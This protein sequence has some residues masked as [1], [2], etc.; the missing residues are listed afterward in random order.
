MNTLFLDITYTG[1]HLWLGNLA[2]LGI[3]LSFVGSLLAV[4][5]Y[6]H[7]TRNRL[8]PSEPGWL[9]VGRVGFGLH[10]LGVFAVIALIFTAMLNQWYEYKYVFDH[11]SPEL[12]QQYIFS[13][14]WEG[15]EGSFLLWMFWNAILGV[16]VLLRGGKFEAPVLVMI[17]LL[18]LILCS[19]I[20]GIKLPWWNEAGY[21]VLGSNPTLL[22]REAM[23]APIFSRPD[24]VNM[25][26]GTGLNPLLQNYWMTIHPPTLFLG[27]ASV[28]L[29]F[30]HAFAGL[31]LNDRTDWIQ[32]TLRWSLFSAA[33]LG[34]GILMGGAWAYVAL[35]FGGYWA[36]DPVENMSLVPWILL[37]AG[38]HT[39]LITRATK[40]GLRS[41]YAFLAAAFFMILFSTFLTRSGVL[42]ESSVHAFTEMGLEVQ[43]VIMLAVFF[44]IGMFGAVLSMKRFAPSEQ[45]SESFFSRELWMVMGSLILLV[46]A[47]LISHYTSIPVYNQLLSY[48][49]DQEINAPTDPVDHHNRMQ[50]FVGVLIGLASGIAVFLRF[51]ERRFIH[52][53]SLIFIGIATVLSAIGTAAWLYNAPFIQAWQYK[54]LAFS[55]VFAV[56][57]N[58]L[59]L[60]DISFDKR[61]RKGGTLFQAAATAMS[62]VGFGLMLIGVLLSGLDKQVISKGFMEVNTIEGFDAEEAAKNVLLPRGVPTQLGEYTATYTEDERQGPYRKFFVDFVKTD[63]QT[64]KVIESFTL[65]PNVIYDKTLSKIEASNPSTQHYW[66][67][68]V[69]TYASAMPQSETDAQAAQKLEDSLV[70]VTHVLKPSDTLAIQNATVKLEQIDRGGS[71][72]K[73]KQKEGDLV[74][75]AYVSVN[76]KTGYKAMLKPLYVIRGNRQLNYPDVDKRAGVKVKFTGLD[77]GSL[78][79]QNPELQGVKLEIAD[80]VVNDDYIVLQ[81][82]VFPGINLVWIGSIMMMFGFLVAL[83]RR[84]MMR[85]TAARTSAVQQ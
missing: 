65:T 12:N 25:I 54:L 17:A 15:Q 78:Q 66:N 6:F 58:S 76:T 21:I 31:W 2:H 67:Q 73:Y 42:G 13:A 71:H 53:R 4:S 28:T 35:T 22:L 20:L 43:L 85:N 10:T 69:F 5:G 46:S 51:K 77:L 56:I 29:P 30:A 82:I 55:A 7:A 23:D 27:F 1:E 9:T 26:S 68:D 11:V 39:L 62:H 64:E 50:L 8:T 33:I 41:S 72:L 84:S 34:T 63:K 45:E 80:N 32:P 16:V 83:I 52:K 40:R 59:V 14:F 61:R 60:L 75:Q 18:Q 19:M 70:Y 48:F 24:Y 37:V 47:V 74:F 38:I 44:G 3:I 57:A 36:W 79:G 49:T 81:A